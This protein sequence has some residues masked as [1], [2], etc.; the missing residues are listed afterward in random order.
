MFDF[1]QSV[2]LP[3]EHSKLIH[4][5]YNVDRCAVGF[6]TSSLWFMRQGKIDE[7]IQRCDYI[8]E[9]ILPSFD[10]EDVVGL[11][12]VLLPIVLVLKWTDDVNRASDLYEQFTPGKHFGLCVSIF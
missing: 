5:T 11:F 12:S 8:A 3:E 6:A 9:Q 1:M 10:Q 2:Y 7:A 4:A